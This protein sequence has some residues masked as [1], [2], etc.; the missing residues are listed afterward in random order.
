MYQLKETDSW[1]LSMTAVPKMGVWMDYCDIWMLNEYLR[2][3][4]LT[5]PCS[6]VYRST[7]S[8]A[9]NGSHSICIRCV[10]PN[11][12]QCKWFLEWSTWNWMDFKFSKKDFLPILAAFKLNFTS[13]ESQKANRWKILNSL[14]HFTPPAQVLMLRSCGELGFERESC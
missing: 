9:V 5:L 3:Y 1:C 13:N 10:Y 2:I 4:V 11:R 12:R 8:S 7:E 6:R 14:F